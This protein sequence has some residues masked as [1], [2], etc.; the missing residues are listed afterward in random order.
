METKTI[1]RLYSTPLLHAAVQ[2][3]DIVYLSGATPDDRDAGMGGQT[4]QALDKVAKWLEH[5]GSDRSRML[6]SMV[7]LKDISLYDEMNEAWGAWFQGKDQPTRAVVA[8]ASL[9]PR[10]LIEIVVTAAKR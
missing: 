1:N 4:T 6:T 3:G 8:V 2:Y 10:S 7:Y 5:F 9:G